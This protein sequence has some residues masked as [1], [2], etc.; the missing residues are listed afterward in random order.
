MT[1]GF[2]KHNK[3]STTDL[4]DDF[5]CAFQPDALLLNKDTKFSTMSFGAIFNLVFVGLCLTILQVVLAFYGS[6][7]SD[8][9]TALYGMVVGISVVKLF[10]SNVVRISAP[11]TLARWHEWSVSHRNII[12]CSEIPL[13]NAVCGTAVSISEVQ[14]CARGEGE[15][16]KTEPIFEFRL[17]R[18]PMHWA[19]RAV[20]P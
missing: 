1:P 14:N 20:L 19:C 11:R 18:Y 7:Q 9:N 15:I 3:G 17:P 2:A 4:R 8:G 5:E 10:V 16:H 13:D 12:G 6:R